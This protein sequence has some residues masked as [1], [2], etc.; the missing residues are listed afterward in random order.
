MASILQRPYRKM[1]KQRG[2]IYFGGEEREIHVKNLSLSGVLAELKSG[3]KN[4]PIK[5]IFDN[6]KQSTAV[7]LFLPE[8]GLNGECE[9]IRVDMI[10]DKIL[11][12]LEFKHISYDTDNFVY[13]RKA[14]RK[15]LKGRGKIL[16][17][18]IYYDFDTVN[19]SVDGLMVQLNDVVKV[20]DGTVTVFELE[21]LE[22]NGEIK[23]IWIEHLE[24]DKTLIG[25]QF[26]TMENTVIKGIPRFAER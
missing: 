3:A 5:D 16:L 23:V 10:K 2:L 9:V 25:L 19:V 15:K 18:G 8:M 1:L 21:Q 4:N 20:K 12:A 14:Y 17:N 13:S 6:L 24:N 22:L 26:L 11:L 7:D